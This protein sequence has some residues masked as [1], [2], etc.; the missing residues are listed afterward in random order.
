MTFKG[1]FMTLMQFLLLAVVPYAFVNGTL[2]WWLVALFMYTL[3]AGV[4]VV[5]T[6]HRLLAHRTF[7]SSK[8]YRYV[9]TF[10]AA[11]G[12]LLSPLE[13]VQQHTAHHRFVDTD[14]DPHSPV[15]MGWKAALFYF[16]KESKGTLFVM[17][18][19]KER[20]M[21][22]MHQFFYPILALYVFFLWLIGGIN[23][24]VFAWAIPCLATLWGQVLAVM[25]H[26]ENGATNGSWLSRIVTFNETWHKYHHENPG[27]IT[28]DGIP[29]WFIRLIRKD[30]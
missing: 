26:D 3:Y 13:W 14:K 18:L 17:R 21:R 25:A 29:Y 15:V 27:D 1:G 22:V 10:F 8:L 16:H 4:G 30:K 20:F 12:S 9:S 19:A 6:Y 7:K 28:K 5:V 11:M 23:A 24:V 2:G